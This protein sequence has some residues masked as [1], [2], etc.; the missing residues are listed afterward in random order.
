MSAKKGGS[1]TAGNGYM[2][3]KN[4]EL[5]PGKKIVQTWHSTDFP[6]GAEDSFLEIILEKTGKG[7]KLFLTHSNI[8]EG[9]QDSYK[10]GWKDF[11]FTPMKKYFKKR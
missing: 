6:E 5:E 7:T 4:L 11:Y 8:P 2:W 3:G 9:Q 1:Y 10:Q